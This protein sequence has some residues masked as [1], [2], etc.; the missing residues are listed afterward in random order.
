[1]TGNAAEFAVLITGTHA[2]NGNYPETAFAVGY[3]PNGNFLIEAT[4]TSK[5][6]LNYGDE[7]TVHDTVTGEEIVGPWIFRAT[8]VDTA[9]KYPGDSYGIWVQYQSNSVYKYFSNDSFETGDSIPGPDPNNTSYTFPTN[10]G[11]TGTAGTVDFWRA[12]LD[13][14]EQAA[15][16]A[17]GHPFAKVFKVLPKDGSL[18]HKDAGATF[19]DKVSGGSAGLVEDAF[20]L[21][22][23]GEAR[24]IREAA[25]AYVNAK[26]DKF[27]FIIDV[28]EIS[29]ATAARKG[30]EGDLSDA[31]SNRISK[32]LGTLTS[33]DL[34]GDYRLGGHE[35]V[36]ALQDVYD[37]NAAKTDFFDHH[38]AARL[39]RALGDMNAMDGDLF[40]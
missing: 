3:I 9:N 26:S 24:L 22:G 4:D 23:G 15:P 37:T 33:I 32:V 28:S 8:G 13:L 40:A 35:I 1:M 11:L 29:G 10:G 18:L 31:E 16:A 30:F 38:D 2:N 34:N 39:G 36:K 7:F 20:F 12:H 19:G 6:V 5:T 25:A 14:L 17:F 27:D 21:H